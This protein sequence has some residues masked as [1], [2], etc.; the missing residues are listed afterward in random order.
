MGRRAPLLANLHDV[1]S[2]PSP[3]VLL[4]ED[5]GSEVAHLDEALPPDP[6]VFPVL[7]GPFGEDGVIQG[8]LEALQVPYVGAGVLRRPSAWTRAS[9]NPSCMT[10]GCR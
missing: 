5:P 10:T 6:V 1:E 2:L 8:H 3:D 9:R 7:H 4:S